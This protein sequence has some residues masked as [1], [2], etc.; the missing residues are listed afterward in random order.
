M[1]RS[2]LAVVVGYLVLAVFVSV[3]LMI[4]WI[5]VGPE[6]AFRAG[7]TRVAPA[8]LAINIPLSLAGAVLGGWIA[9]LIGRHPRNT[10]VKVL[11]GLV[12][13]LGLL[14]AVML[15]TT[16]R[17]AP[18]KPVTEMS[19]LEASAHGQ[20]PVWYSFGIPILGAAAVIL[21]GKLYRPRPTPPPPPAI[22]DRMAA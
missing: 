17:P 20:Q 18:T 8:W 4:G 16:V 22:S 15:V 19:M 11:A 5:A 14:Q 7:T 2:I 3:T 9:A 21:G 12:L 13:V 6:V 1:L 10:P